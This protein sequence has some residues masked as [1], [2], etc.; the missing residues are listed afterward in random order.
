MEERR[1]NKNKEEN[2]QTEEFA[3]QK[4]KFKGKFPFK[5]YYCGLKGHKKFECKKKL[6]DKNCSFTRDKEEEDIAFLTTTIARVRSG[7]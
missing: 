5:C 1:Q 2:S 4:K 3:A 7:L 6:D